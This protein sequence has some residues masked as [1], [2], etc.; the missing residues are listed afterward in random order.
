[1]LAIGIVFVVYACTFVG[2]NERL[3]GGAKGGFFVTWACI[4]GVVSLLAWI[5]G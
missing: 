5:T 2:C 1:M 4:V 3:D